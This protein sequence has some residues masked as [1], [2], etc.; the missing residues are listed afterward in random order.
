MRTRGVLA[1][2]TALVSGGC[3]APAQV[4]APTTMS[5]P[6]EVLKPEGDGPFP[7]IVM[8]HDCS[9]LG[10]KSSGSPKRWAN[11]LIKQGYVIVIPD[12][13]SSRG[14]ADGVCTMPY[15]IRAGV[16]PLQ[17]VKDAYEALQHA[18]SLPYVD[19]SRVGVMGGSHGGS[20][21][22]Q[23]LVGGKGFAAGVALYPGCTARIGEWSP[24]TNGVYKPSAPL[25]ILSGALDDWTPAEPCRRMLEISN[26]AG[27][28]VAMKIYP[29]AHHSFDSRSPLRYNAERVNANV[30]GGR[31]ATTQGNPEAWK[32][33][34]EE[35]SA[36]FARHLKK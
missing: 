36:F 32:D 27:Y 17:R 3:A 4:A 10:P 7:A 1:L 9:G 19:G 26:G 21:T 2:V 6:T 31:G 22:L 11:L 13:F 5:V 18:R 29:N 28:D 15:Q 23:T 30:P 8:L 25:Y 12:S 14:I 20:T 16:S 24:G 34:I 33:S 35:V